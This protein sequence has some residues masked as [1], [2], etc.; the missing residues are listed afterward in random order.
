MS[1]VL[2]LLLEDPSFSGGAYTAPGVFIESLTLPALVGD[3]IDTLPG[4]FDFSLPVPV[5]YD[6]FKGW[7]L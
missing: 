4:D 5:I 1:N 6:F 7:L 2:S 3:A